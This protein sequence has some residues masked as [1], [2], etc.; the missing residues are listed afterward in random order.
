[1]GR[2]VSVLG[3]AVCSE[4][5][6]V[7]VLG[8]WRG[9]APLGAGEGKD[10]SGGWGGNSLGLDAVELLRRKSWCEESQDGALGPWGSTS[11]SLPGELS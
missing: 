8:L 1:M 7:G 2:Q 9:E 4:Y 3:G 5:L 6:E 11:L 10:E